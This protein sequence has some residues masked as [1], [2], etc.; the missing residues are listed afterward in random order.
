MWQTIVK[1]A[2]MWNKK[3]QNRGKKMMMVVM[4]MSEVTAMPKEMVKQVSKDV[5]TFPLHIDP[6]AFSPAPSMRPL[7]NSSISPWTYDFSHDDNCFPPVLSEARCLLKGCLDANGHEDQS[8]HSQPL[9][10]QGLLLRR[11]TAP[12]GGNQ[13]HFRLESR[14]YA[15]GCVCVRPDVVTQE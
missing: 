6:T 3:R 13:N 11:I 9:M 15:V 5:Q 4:M 7:H 8:L 14:L 2:K 10:Q 12:E 1:K